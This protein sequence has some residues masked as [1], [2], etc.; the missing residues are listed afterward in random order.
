MKRVY[1]GTEKY[2]AKPLNIKYFKTD[3]VEKTD[4][5]LEFMLLANVKALVELTHGVDLS[6][7]DIAIIT[8][9]SEL[10]S[11]DLSGLSTIYMRSQTHKMLDREQLTL[12]KGI[13]IIDI[14]ETFFPKEMREVGL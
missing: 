8:K 14:P 5:D 13:E 2:E 4:E 6:K 1:S 7:S 12:L 9:R 10:D 11:L 3:F